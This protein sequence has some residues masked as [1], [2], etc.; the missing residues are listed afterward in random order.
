MG[1]HAYGEFL[2]GGCLAAGTL[3]AFTL[4]NAGK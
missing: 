1:I 2:E 3:V 4:E